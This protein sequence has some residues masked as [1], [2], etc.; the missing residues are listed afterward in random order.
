MALRRVALFRVFDE[1]SSQKGAESDSGS[2]PF[3]ICGSDS[4][5]LYRLREPALVRLTP[6]ARDDRLS[7]DTAAPVS[8]SLPMSS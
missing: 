3:I 6:D 4:R 1:S 8:S 5:R 7:V 2:A